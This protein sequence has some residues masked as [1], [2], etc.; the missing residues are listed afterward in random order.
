[1]E[2]ASQAGAGDEVVEVL[3]L[4]GEVGPPRVAVLVEDGGGR[5]EGDTELLHDLDEDQPAQLVGVVH[6]G[7]AAPGG[8]PDQAA[9]LVVPQGRGVHAERPRRLTD[10]DQSHA[11][12]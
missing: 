7:S 11:G 3:N 12:I 10:A 6:A 2:V 4:L 5:V 9:L 8:R 1:Q